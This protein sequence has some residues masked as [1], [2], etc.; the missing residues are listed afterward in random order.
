MFVS[1]VLNY[2]V[3]IKISVQVVKAINKNLCSTN[4]I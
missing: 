2:F 4:V 3:S 1:F